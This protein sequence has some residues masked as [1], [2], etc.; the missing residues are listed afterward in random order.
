MIE[1]INLQV[2]D[3]LK[4]DSKPSVVITASK[5]QAWG[6]EQT[7]PQQS[8]IWPTSLVHL[9]TNAKA[10]QARLDID[11]TAWSSFTVTSKSCDSGFHDLTKQIPWHLTRQ[12]E[13]L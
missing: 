1:D 5:V 10:S 3:V 8:L 13:V 2:I 12:T 7:T 6:C 4:G 11:S 9:P